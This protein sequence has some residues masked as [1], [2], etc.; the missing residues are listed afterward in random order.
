MEKEKSNFAPLSENRISP[1]SEKTETPRKF[2]S[3]ENRRTA[4]ESQKR[5][6]S[7]FSQF[8]RI[9]LETKRTSKT[10]AGGRRFSFASL[11]LVKDKNKGL[12]SFSYSK[13]KEVSTAFQKMLKKAHRNFAHFSKKI[14][15]SQVFIP[16][17]S[18]IPHNIEIS[19]KTITL[20]IKPAPSGTGIRAG[21]VLRKI[22]KMIGFKDISAKIIGSG[23]NLNITR[24]AFLALSKINWNKNKKSLIS[25]EKV[26]KQGV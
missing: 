19:Y 8:E 18:T 23:N 17:S 15:T 1:S 21:G 7:P 16:A 14:P 6:S 11:G 3:F 26:N 25:E 2:G 20:L 9:I 10:T 12:V 4:R 22:F 24:A 13:G 5:T